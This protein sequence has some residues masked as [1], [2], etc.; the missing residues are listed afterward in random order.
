MSI[1]TFSSSEIKKLSSNPNIIKV[2]HK[3]ITYKETFKINFIHEYLAG[4][5]PRV[6]FEKYK[7]D[8]EIVGLKRIEQCA[9]R[10][11]K[12]YLAQGLLGLQDSRSK[13][14]G[15]PSN[16]PLTEEQELNKLKARIHFLEMEN[17]FL[18]KLKALERL[19]P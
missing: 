12:Q 19:K 15:R 2:S 4:S 1:K 8:F 5:L 17:D 11:K 7:L 9:S 10:W 6:I 18:K 13:N 3:S 14:S 16:K